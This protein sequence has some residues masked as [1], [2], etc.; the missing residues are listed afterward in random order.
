MKKY[1]K[2]INESKRNVNKVLTRMK[3]VK[4]LLTNLETVY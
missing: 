3:L 1:R 4:M 2:L